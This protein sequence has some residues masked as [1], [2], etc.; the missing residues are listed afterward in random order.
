MHYCP[1]LFCKFSLDISD[2]H[3]YATPDTTVIEGTSVS[4]TC[5]KLSNAIL[6]QY[7]W[8]KGRQVVGN[9]STLTLA[10]IQKE[11]SGLYYCRIS[12]TIPNTTRTITHHN[13]KYLYVKCKL[14]CRAICSRLNFHKNNEIIYRSWTELKLV[15]YC[16]D[17]S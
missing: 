1:N 17:N 13:S 6:H 16:I 9:S 14:F 3:I 15:A 12:A 4:L 10:S 8:L 7:E 2:V 11:D 5:A